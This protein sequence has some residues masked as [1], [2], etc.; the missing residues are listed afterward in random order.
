MKQFYFFVVKNERNASGQNRTVLHPIPGQNTRPGYYDTP[1]DPALKVQ[2]SLG[3]NTKAVRLSEGAIVGVCHEGAN[4]QRCALKSYSR[5][6][7]PFYRT[8]AE[9]FLVY[10]NNDRDVSVPN[11]TVANA[12]MMIAYA[13]VTSAACA[14]SEASD[15]PL[16]ERA[17]SCDISSPESET[18][19]SSPSR[20]AQVVTFNPEELRLIEDSLRLEMNERE[21]L[22]KLLTISQI[23]D[24]VAVGVARFTYIKQNGETRVAYGT[25]NR[26]VMQ[27]VEYR[28]TNNQDRTR[29]Q[30][31]GH[32]VYFD[33]GRGDWRSFCTPDIVSCDVSFFL[34]PQQTREIR[35]LA[36]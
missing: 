8:E 21:A 12:E 26:E 13:Q 6:N 35:A 19:A 32:F 36:S 18:P 3:E 11:L 7:V 17:D 20:T 25:R 34:G 24:R 1:V 2:L 31:G 23:K 27:Q 28:G 33:L 9:I 30:D 29:Q 16:A 14:A 15:S 4:V 10:S 5:A 22:T